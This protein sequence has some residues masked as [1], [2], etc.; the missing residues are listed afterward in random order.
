MDKTV[1]D[2]LIEISDDHTE[3]SERS[4]VYV[5]EPITLNSPARISEIE[6]PGDELSCLNDGGIHDGKTLL[7]TASYIHSFMYPDWTMED[8]F[9]EVRKRMCHR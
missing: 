3:Y 9:Y 2:L 1:L 5:Q 7:A 6:T 8:V 4:A